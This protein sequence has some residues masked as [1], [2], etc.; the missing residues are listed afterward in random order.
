MIETPG[1]FSP[2]E[3]ETEPPVTR[4]EVESVGEIWRVDDEWW[5]Q[6]VSRRYV[7][8]MMKGGKHMVLYEDLVTGEWF[9]QSI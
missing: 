4:R 7:E 5:R 9:A 6:P 3:G 1:V 8:V 2:R